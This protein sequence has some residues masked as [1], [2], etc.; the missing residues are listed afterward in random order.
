MISS[1]IA[2]NQQLISSMQQVIQMA[3]QM[4]DQFGAHITVITMGPPQADLV[5]REAFAMGVDR[6]PFIQLIKDAI[7]NLAAQKK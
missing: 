5:L 6:V 7:A 3:L 2:Q 1:T 4:K